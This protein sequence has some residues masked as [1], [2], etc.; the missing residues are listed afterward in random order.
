MNMKK[1]IASGLMLV[2]LT[3]ISGCQSLPFS[4]KQADKPFSF[5]LPSPNTEKS[6]AYYTQ[7]DTFNTL[8]DSSPY[9]LGNQESDL[10]GMVEFNRLKKAKIS[11]AKALTDN[12]YASSKKVEAGLAPLKTAYLDL[13]GT[14]REKDKMLQNFSLQAG[15]QM[16]EYLTQES[17]LRANYESIETSRIANTGVSS[18]FDYQKTYLSLAYADTVLQDTNTFLTS[19]AVL[20]EL[21]KDNKDTEIKSLLTSFDQQ[22]EGITKLQPDLMEVITQTNNLDTALKQINTGDYYLAKATV[23]Y[24][25]ESFPDLTEKVKSLTPSTNLTTENIEAITEYTNSFEDFAALF[26]MQILKLDTKQLIPAEKLAKLPGKEVKNPWGLEIARATTAPSSFE[27]LA[28]SYKALNGDAPSTA[29]K[30]AGTIKD[31]AS[32]SWLFDSGVS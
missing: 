31:V 22:M 15:G 1:I 14:A 2:T 21:L 30:I 3:S 4:E 32:T 24:M 18:L 17:A 12:L 5:A 10:P 13:L 20:V 25:E 26:N 7:N 16:T 28:Q 27:T 11:E 29:S 23:E 19:S 9:Y 8:T 6:I